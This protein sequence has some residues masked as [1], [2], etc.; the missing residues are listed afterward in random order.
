M[1]HEEKYDAGGKELTWKLH[2]TG[3]T[4][5]HF[6]GIQNPHQVLPR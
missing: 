5:Q 1:E 2:N 4:V 6:M 3:R